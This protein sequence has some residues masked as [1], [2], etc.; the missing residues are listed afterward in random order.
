MKGGESLYERIFSRAQVWCICRSR[1]RS[2]IDGSGSYHEFYAEDGSILLGG[3]QVLILE[4][5][6][7]FAE[8][9]S[10]R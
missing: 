2:H 4:M 8:E 5:K 6:K 10:D 3:Y 9:N 7:D 1:G